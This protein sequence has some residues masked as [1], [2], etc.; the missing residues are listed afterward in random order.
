[1]LHIWK[2]I[3]LKLQKP[4]LNFDFCPL[5]ATKKR[6]VT[7]DELHPDLLRSIPD[8]ICGGWQ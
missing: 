2:Y 8:G 6:R 1:M 4:D 7:A 3:F 5:C